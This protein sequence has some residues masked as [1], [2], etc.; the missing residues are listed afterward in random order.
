MSAGDE[1][2]GRITGRGGGARQADVFRALNDSIGFDWRLAPYDVDQSIA[3]AT[4]LAAQEIISD[5]DR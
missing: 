4:M 3:H 1:F 5:S 2:E